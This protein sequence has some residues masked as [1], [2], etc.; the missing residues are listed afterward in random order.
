[1]GAHVLS[2]VDNVSG[3]VGKTAVQLALGV[4]EYTQIKH[5]FSERII[6]LLPDALSKLEQYTDE[7]LM[8]ESTLTEKM[9]SLPFHEFERLLHPVFEEDEWYTCTYIHTTVTQHITRHELQ[10]HD[11]NNNVCGWTMCVGARV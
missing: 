7:A 6:T 5:D 3:A 1:M 10:H 8:M 4:D 11:H 2:A 9:Q